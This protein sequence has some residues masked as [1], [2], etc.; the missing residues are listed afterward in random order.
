MDLSHD[1]GT[2]QQAGQALAQR[3]VI[4]GQSHP[5]PARL[6]TTITGQD[7]AAD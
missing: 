5:V 6:Q 2:I 4:V 7:Q 3:D 1:L